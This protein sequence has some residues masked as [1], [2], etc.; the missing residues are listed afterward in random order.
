MAKHQ[1]VLMM[2]TFNLL[3]A[4]TVSIAI[5]FNLATAHVSYGHRQA[6]TASML[7]KN[8]KRA[9]GRRRGEDDT[10]DIAFQPVKDDEGELEEEEGE[11]A[12]VEEDNDLGT[13]STLE[14][15]ANGCF[16]E[17]PLMSTC[18][19]ID[20]KNDRGILE[21]KGSIS[22]RLLR[23]QGGSSGNDRKKKILIFDF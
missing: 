1:A 13:N 18:S 3:V 23:V 17:E 14:Y 16:N 10:F 5:G 19:G 15:V 9:F 21:M 12:Y 20:G 22:K 2:I 11:D 7:S 6:L 8:M 4:L